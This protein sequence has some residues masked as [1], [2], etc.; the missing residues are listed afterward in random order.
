MGGAR[1]GAALRGVLHLSLSD[2]FSV[3]VSPM[4]CRACSVSWPRPWARSS[5][6]MK[7]ARLEPAVAMSPPAP[8]NFRRGSLRPAVHPHAPFPA[9]HDDPARHH[10]LALRAPDVTS[11]WRLASPFWSRRA[12]SRIPWRRS[13]T[14]PFSSPTA[15]TPFS[16]GSQQPRCRSSR[17]SSGCRES[18]ARRARFPSGAPDQ[19]PSRKARFH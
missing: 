3:S 1:P 9:D 10:A 7:A 8:P 13:S 14:S 18:C 17:I 15:R 12:S 11:A 2:L 5:S 16:D 19:R 4:S 6:A